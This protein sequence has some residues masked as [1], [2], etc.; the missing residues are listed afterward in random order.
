MQSLTE[1][2]AE[3]PHAYDFGSFGEGQS[4]PADAANVFADQF[5]SAA[6]L[7]GVEI[8]LRGNFYCKPPKLR[9]ERALPTIQAHYAEGD[10]RSAL[11]VAVSVVSPLLFV[12][13]GSD[14]RPASEDEIDDEFSS[15]EVM[16]I[17][18]GALG[19]KLTEVPE[20]NA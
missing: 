17:L 1:K 14:F 12:W 8:H 11:D 4:I 15:E 19:V 3:N 9:Q 13:D 10:L 6:A 18:S 20:G 5:H 16:G 2:R 7:C